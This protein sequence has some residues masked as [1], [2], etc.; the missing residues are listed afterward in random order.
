[1]NL[2]IG[3]GYDLDPSL[4][5]YEDPFEA[6]A[7]LSALLRGVDGDLDEVEAVGRRSQTSRLLAQRRFKPSTDEVEQATRN[8]VVARGGRRG[9]APT[10]APA[11]IFG[12]VPDLTSSAPVDDEVEGM[13]PIMDPLHNA[14][15]IAKQLAMLEDHLIHPS[16]RCHD[17]IR[18]HLLTAEGLAEEAV[19][20]SS[21]ADQHRV[22]GSAAVRLRGV[23]RSFLQG[24][25]K[26]GL[27]QQIRGLRK[28]M[29]KLGF[30]SI[31]GQR[32]G[33]RDVNPL[34]GAVDRTS[35]QVMAVAA[36]RGWPAEVIAAANVSVNKAYQR[37]L[38]SGEAESSKA[39]FFQDLLERWDNFPY[40]SQFAGWER[41]A[42]AWASG[43]NP[44]RLNRP[45]PAV[46]TQPLGL[47][48]PPIAPDGAPTLAA[49]SAAAAGSLPSLPVGAGVA[50]RGGSG[51]WARGT[52]DGPVDASGQIP[53]RVSGSV[54]LY[55]AQLFSADLKKRGAVPLAPG[56]VLSSAPISGQLRGREIPIISAFSASMV[57]LS[58][59]QLLMADVIQ[60]VFEPAFAGLPAG[61][62]TRLAQAAVVNALY[63]SRLDPLASRVGGRD[64]SWGLFQC[65]RMGGLGSGWSTEE[66]QNPIIN[67]TIIASAVA[68]VPRQRVAPLVDA[69]P[70]APA[71]AWVRWMTIEVIRPADAVVAGERRAATADAIAGLVADS[72]GLVPAP[73]AIVDSLRASIS[74]IT[75][76][77]LGLGIAAVAALSLGA[78]ALRT[79]S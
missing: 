72:P 62:A 50:I 64:D 10:R 5:P 40:H 15:E 36:A 9:A 65:N 22:F 24:A 43:F 2:R 17:C 53:V 67:A 76:M 57:R 46:V 45:E 27:Q 21:D 4:L 37:A 31:L 58:E 66:L 6:D 59:A 16:K 42:R 13:L 75:P 52:V 48:S 41:L 23:S 74:A 70:L 44:Q 54:V 33:S 1:M 3:P 55:P 78:I 60:A 73:G 68:D 34:A 51:A 7:D 8:I 19:S 79:R 49:P 47:A 29:G 63:E 18:K 14:R 61:V 77:E 11:Q 28:E 35:K 38:Q 20:L 39:I 25:D 69:A 56:I 12:F 71:S 26:A 32:A 30:D